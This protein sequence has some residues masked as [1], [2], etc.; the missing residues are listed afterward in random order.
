M[1]KKEF[2]RER[3]K[4]KSPA[5]VSMWIGL[6]VALVGLISLVILN[7]TSLKEGREWQFTIFIAIL[8][9]GFFILFFALILRRIRKKGLNYFVLGAITA[10]LGFF[11]MALPLI[12]YIITFKKGIGIKDYVMFTI[13]GIGVFLVIFGF[14]IEA[15]E[16]NV[17]FIN[18]LKNIKKSLKKLFKRIKWNLIFSPWNLLSCIGITVIVLTALRILNLVHPVYSY[19][20]GGVLVLINLFILFHKEIV[21]ILEDVGKLFVTIFHSWWKGVRAIPSYIARLAR[22]LFDPERFRRLIRFLKEKI[23][24]ICTWIWKI[25]KFV[26][27]HNYLLLF[28][29]GIA[30]YFLFN[31]LNQ[32]TRIALSS[33]VCS[34]AVVKPILDWREHFGE[35][36]S[37]ARLFLYKTSQKTWN[38]L[39]F[40]KIIHCP[41]CLQPNPVI[42]RNCWNCK[43]EIPRCLI[44][45]NV[46]ERGSE[47]VRCK[48]CENIFHSNHLKTWLRFNFKCP[49]C[50]QKMEK[51]ERSENF[52]PKV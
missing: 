48:S 43:R 6:G 49:V 24:F 46:V 18:L 8:V 35:D 23:I 39:H 45:G 36:I 7:I 9:S 1:N 34:V 17:K 42:R 16:L 21:A 52:N 12:I 3:K 50:K 38:V 29:F 4:G 25:L 15:Y 51:E 47:I 33:L 41:Y 20:I 31:V 26:I 5:L 30:L 40:N 13:M 2:L 44:C 22:F 28:A 32:E 19:T 37:R 11:M 14:I 10:Y 27:L